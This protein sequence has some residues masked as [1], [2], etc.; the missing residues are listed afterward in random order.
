MLAPIDGF[1]QQGVRYDLRFASCTAKTA[2][3]VSGRVRL[4]ARGRSK[5][6][7]VEARGF[8]D[9]TL[10][11]VFSSDARVSIPPFDLWTTPAPPPQPHP[12]ATLA[13]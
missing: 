3:E 12:T 8:R 6:L 10:V 11:K 2:V 4:S 9:P 5:R 13:T 1:A 7:F